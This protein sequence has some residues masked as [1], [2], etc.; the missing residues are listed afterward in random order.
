MQWSVFLLKLEYRSCQAHGPVP[1]CG[2][3]F[4]EMLHP[5]RPHLNRPSRTRT[6]VSQGYG[7]AH[8]V[9]LQRVLV[10]PEGRIS[11]VLAAG[12]RSEVQNSVLNFWWR[13]L[14]AML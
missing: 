11:D 6:S 9:Q 2:L 8:Q 3:G 7:D 5:H 14:A 13:V 12:A 10:F 4:R 1:I